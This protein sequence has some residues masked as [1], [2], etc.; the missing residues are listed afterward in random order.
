MKLPKT[1]SLLILAVAMSILTLNCS[2]TSIKNSEKTKVNNGKT[3]RLKWKIDKEQDIR[4]ETIMNDI[5]DP[6]FDMNFGGIFD[7]LLDSTSGNKKEM[8]NFFKKFQNMF[9]D[10]QFIT[11]L[12]NSDHFDNVFDITMS[13]K[14]KE[15]TKEDNDSSNDA[16]DIMSKMMQKMTKG[17]MLRGSLYKD[18]GL[19]SFWNKNAQKN[20]VSLFFELPAKDLSIGDTWTLSN[21]N[22]LQFDQNFVCEKAQKKNIITLTEI[23]EEDGNQIALIDYD[24]LEYV[25]GVFENPF[26]N[27]KINTKMRMVYKAQA[28]FSI[29]KGRWVGYTGIMSIDASGIMNSKQKKKFALI[30]VE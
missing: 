16:S 23:I 3:V 4:Y 24:I 21:V 10:T 7:K 29:T 19:Q 20:L 22:L 17:V 8:K 9:N 1:F 12:S 6:S 25:Y 11:V 5:I 27:K 26:Q 2:N 13:T 18:G 15:D 30:E 14:P 28:K